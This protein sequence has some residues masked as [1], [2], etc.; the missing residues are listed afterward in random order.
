MKV[1][2]LPSAVPLVCFLVSSLAACSDDKTIFHPVPSGDAGGD[3]AAGSGDASS[4]GGN[5][6]HGGKPQGGTTGS[7][8]KATGGESAGGSS[9]TAGKSGTS[10]APAVTCNT[11]P[12][13]APEMKWVNATGNLAG[14][15]SECGNLGLVSAQPCSP[16]VIAGVAKKGLWETLDGGKTWRALGTSAGSDAISNRIS[17]IVYDPQDPNVFWES[18][19]YNGGGVYQTKDSGA[20]FAQLGEIS[21]CD[22]VSVDLSDPA[23]QTLLAG[24]HEANSPLHLSTNGGETWSNIAQGLPGG[25]CTSTLIIDALTFL[26]GCNSGSI[27]RTVN[28]GMSWES[29]AGSSG[30]TFQP[31]VAKDGTIYWPG[32]NGGVSVSEDQGKT[33]ETVADA[34]LVPNIVAPA[35]FAEL[36]DGRVVV[37]GHDYL[38]ASADHGE[39]WEPVGEKLPYPGGGYDGTHGLTYSEQTKTF[40]VWRWDCQDKVP[41]NAIMSMGFDWETQ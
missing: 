11:K 24:T 1:R 36:P 40:F 16:R 4:T 14:M 19:I 39:H 29:A 23:H 22:S 27:V 15:E 32:S 35:Q 2:L 34:G 30:G 8:G 38:L 41:E 20:T 3:G 17:S 7:A 31:L 5:A 10:G 9:S 12:T 26:V 28:G 6:G 21:H 18:G 37:S 25:I 33:F 13:D